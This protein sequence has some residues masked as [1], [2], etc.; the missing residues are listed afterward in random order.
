MKLIATTILFAVSFHAVAQSANTG[1][2][3]RIAQDG[4]TTQ[5]NNVIENDLQETDQSSNEKLVV[6]HNPKDLHDTTGMDATSV[7]TWVDKNGVRWYTDNPKL[8]PRNATTKTVYSMPAATPV[9]G[10]EKKNE[11]SSYSDIE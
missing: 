9:D 7:I 11:Q 5:T 3:Q 8:A 6:S 10:N 2:V 4:Q 1:I